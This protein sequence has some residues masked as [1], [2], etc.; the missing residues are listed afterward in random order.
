M[1]HVHNGDSTAG[2]MREAGFPGEHFPFREALAVGPTPTGVSKDRWVTIRATYLAEVAGEDVD[3]I[4]RDLKAIDRALETITNHEEIILWF[5][6]DVLCQ[7]N[8]SY[9]LARFSGQN[10]GESRLSLICIDEFPG[11]PA[12]RGLG[13][14]TAEQMAS[15]FDTRHEVTEAEM[16]LAKRAWDAYCSPDPRRI[17]RLM[18]EDTSAM[19][20]LSAALGQ[21]LARFPST[22]NGL[23]H[24]ENR[25][26]ELISGGATDFS[27]LCKAFFEAEPSYGL[28][29]LQIWTDLK[30]MAKASRPLI[31]LNGS[32]VAPGPSSRLHASCKITDEGARILK[33]EDDFVNANGI[34][35]WLGGVHLRENNLW[36]WDVG[37]QAL[38]RA[39]V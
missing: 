2:T 27:T 3:N 19:P 33:G 1:L 31:R 11:M 35:L 15:L 26:L 39:A 18:K 4:E 34:D 32:D 22:R 7:I 20:F 17:E 16:S 5:E 9:L 12:F 29:D 6:H 21:H 38:V 30:R 37:N 28:G 13:E 14:L 23:G 36:R 24:A 8:L 25:L 10:I